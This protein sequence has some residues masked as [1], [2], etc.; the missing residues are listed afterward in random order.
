MLL[1]NVQYAKDPH[2]M[3]VV[4]EGK[5]EDI[6]MGT[7]FRGSPDRAAGSSD[8]ARVI[9]ALRRT[10]LQM[11]KRHNDAEGNSGI[12]GPPQHSPLDQRPPVVVLVVHTISTFC[13]HRDPPS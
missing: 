10:P 9:A 12:I 2:A 7:S 4:P 6:R 13:R 1:E 11:F 5:S 3:A 8:V